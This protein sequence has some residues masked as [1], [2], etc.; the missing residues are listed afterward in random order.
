MSHTFVVFVVFLVLVLCTHST[1]IIFVTEFI[2]R[3][4]HQTPDLLRPHVAELL[5]AFN[6]TSN[7]TLTLLP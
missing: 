7:F 5:S 2:I 4:P 3:K 6:V 1:A